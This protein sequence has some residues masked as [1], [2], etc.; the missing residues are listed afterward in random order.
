MRIDI[1]TQLLELPALYQ[2][3]VRANKAEPEPQKQIGYLIR[4]CNVN[5]YL[6][7][8][9]FIF[10]RKITTFPEYMQGFLIKNRI[11]LRFFVYGV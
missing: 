7:K 1:R 5:T 6:Y 11:L 9:P 3:L 10:R 8:R 2:R 4:R